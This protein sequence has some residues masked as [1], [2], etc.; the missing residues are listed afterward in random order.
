MAL[1]RLCRSVLQSAFPA[2]RSAQISACFYPYIGLTHTIRRK[3]SSWRIRISDHCRNAP[4][5]ALE[6][7]IVL[8]GSKVTRRKP[9]SRYLETYRNYS[10]EASI[11]KAVR[12]RRL[13]RGRKLIAKGAP[14]FHALEDICREINGRYFDNR[15]HIA[16]IGWGMRRSWSR[17]GHYD[18][19]HRTIILSPVLDAAEVPGFVVRYIVYHEMLHAVF[20][21]DLPGAANR[22]HPYPFR[23]AEEAYPDFAR[24]KEFLREYCRR[25]ASR[26]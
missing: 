17:L 24:A 10:K 21:D 7:I 12:E 18:P 11:V 5:P 22:H 8:L 15:V 4:V 13:L 6:A 14:S 2:F 19:V 16:R 1:Q 26:C 9:P 23:R 3:G 20:E 25:R